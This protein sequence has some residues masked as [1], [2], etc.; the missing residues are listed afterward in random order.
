MLMLTLSVRLPTAFPSTT[1]TPPA[2]LTML[3]SSLALTTATDVSLATE[4]LETVASI[5]DT[6]M[7]PTLDIPVPTTAKFTLSSHPYLL[8]KITQLLRFISHLLVF[9]K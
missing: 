4:L 9:L 3:E 7:E 8:E 6:T 1:P 5:V 2:T